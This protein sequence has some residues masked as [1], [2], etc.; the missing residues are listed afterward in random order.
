MI[1]KNKKIFKIYADV[2]FVV[3][4]FDAFNGEWLAL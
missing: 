2:N 3:C 1:F 4:F